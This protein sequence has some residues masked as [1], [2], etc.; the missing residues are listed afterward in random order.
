MLYR[1]TLSVSLTEACNA[2]VNGQTDSIQLSLDDMEQTSEYQC[3]I[4]L[5]TLLSKQDKKHCYK[6]IKPILRPTPPE[7]AW[8]RCSVSLAP[9]VSD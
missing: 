6:L 9:L 4:A 7:K 3:R 1:P 2:C 5:T 8:L